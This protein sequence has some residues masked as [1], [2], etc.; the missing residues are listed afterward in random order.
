MN[1]KL[2]L[3][4]SMLSTLVFF[5]LFSYL[6]PLSK[7]QAKTISKP[8]QLSLS[9]NPPL[10]ITP[11]KENTTSSK[12][13]TIAPGDSFYTL[14]KKLQIPIATL[15]NIQKLPSSKLLL[16]LT[17]G[18]KVTFFFQQKKLIAI[19]K[20]LDKDT[21]IYLDLEKQKISKKPLHTDIETRIAFA[22]GTIKDSLYIAGLRS[23]LSDNL[24]M[25]LI[26]IFA[27]DID[28]N[29]DIRKGDQFSV[30]YEKIYSD[31]SFLRNGRILVAEYI[32]KGKAK[33]A[34]L[35]NKAGK[36]IGYYTL[37]G[38]P[39]KKSFLRSP[40]A[41]TR[42]S[43]RFTLGRYHPILHK[44]RA[45]KGVD[46]A[47]PIGTPVKSVGKGR[48]YFKGYSRGFG[49]TVIIKHANNITTLYAHLSAYRRKLKKGSKVKQGQVIAYVGKS[50][51]ATGPHLHFEFRVNGHH[52]NPL[53]VKLPKAKKL[54][55]K[56][57]K[58]FKQ[59][60][61]PLLLQFNALK[62]SLTPS[63]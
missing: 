31:G 4:L 49:R 41:F 23:G 11:R 33:L 40:V 39:L 2:W 43:S 32:N 20:I 12:Q 16:K 19:E 14:F 48:V 38:S 9:E 7:Q 6:T 53:K 8:L 47:A 61:Q 63:I 57:L 50:G 26:H 51:L 27:W 17:P 35:F 13:L 22:Q 24:I 18:E 54:N 5:G 55:A 1:K 3:I 52:K 59:Q 10:I 46:Y 62:H 44:I 42:I 29:L 58:Q 28:F 15:L 56:D 25:E 36:N 34:I 30:L 60:A 45:H 37:D 21:K